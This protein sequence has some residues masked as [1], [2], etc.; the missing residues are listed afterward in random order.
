MKHFM[1]LQSR[2]T[3][4]CYNLQEDSGTLYFSLSECL[5]CI[6]IYKPDEVH[7][8][9]AQLEGYITTDS[10]FHHEKDY[11]IIDLSSYTYKVANPHFRKVASKLGIT[12]E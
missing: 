5:V 9:K 1:S 2:H 3:G 10:K 4:V 12:V 7:I 11:I 8:Y 6:D